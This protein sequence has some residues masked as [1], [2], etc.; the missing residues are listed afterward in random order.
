[1]VRKLMVLL[2]LH[3]SQQVVN[4]NNTRR[5]LGKIHFLESIRYILNDPTCPLYL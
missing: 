4:W 5:L 2:F 3:S 1:M